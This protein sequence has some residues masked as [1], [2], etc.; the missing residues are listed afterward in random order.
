MAKKKE[1]ESLVHLYDHGY[2]SGYCCHS[3]G[4]GNTRI[5]RWTFDEKIATC[6]KC[7]WRLADN[8]AKEEVRQ[9][10][11]IDK[12]LEEYTRILKHRESRAASAKA[13]REAADELFCEDWD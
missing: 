8:E 5:Q 4:H 9:L 2:E 13:L 7:F 6:P 1:K 10:E 12:Q 11:L 3:N